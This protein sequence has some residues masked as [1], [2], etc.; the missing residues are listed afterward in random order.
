MIDQLLVAVVLAGLTNLLDLAGLTNPR[1]EAE[2]D[3]TA[4]GC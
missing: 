4:R 2:W 1:S 3:Q